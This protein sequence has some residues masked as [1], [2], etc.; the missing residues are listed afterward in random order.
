[1][2]KSLYYSY[3]KANIESYNFFLK[4][5]NTN[6]FSTKVVGNIK[7][8]TLNLKHPIFNSVFNTS[9]IKDDINLPTINNYYKLQKNSNVIKQN[10]FRL[11]NSDEFLNY[12]NKGKGEVYLFSSQ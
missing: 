2:R 3:R 9:K 8:A 4:Q 6:Q 12:Y 5:L 11:E 7:I 10:I 1:M